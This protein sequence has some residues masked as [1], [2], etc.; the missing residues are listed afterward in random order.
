[1]PELLEEAFDVMEVCRNGHVIT[2]RL[3]AQPEL[4]RS[5]CDRCGALTYNR[6]PT[7]GTEIRG[8]APLTGLV[9]VG[10]GQPP[11][12]CATCGAAYPWTR[13]QTTVPP[14][15]VLVVLEPLLRRLPR[16]LRELRLHD[17]VDPDFC[18]T[19]Q[20][21]LE[22]LLRAVLPLC[23]D[24]LRLVGRTPA[25]SLTNRTDFLLLPD[26]VAV[27]SKLV[28]AA[29]CED[30]L[31]QQLQEDAEYYRQQKSCRT[32][33]AIVCDQQDLLHEPRRLET[34]WSGMHD[35]LDVRCI[36]AS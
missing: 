30:E 34:L 1:M 31:Q 17:I 14:A 12:H 27:T 6:C 10:H 2:D 26:R 20:R 15:P 8:A 4:H 28:T 11:W 25:Y 13:R 5:H 7:C 33:V 23:C 3:R 29:G 35:G 24:D 19:N 9:T 21:D 32:L 18:R 36:I 16:S 22:N